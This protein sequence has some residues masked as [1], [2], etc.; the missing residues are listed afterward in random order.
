MKGSS[1]YNSLLFSVA[2]QIITGLVELSALFIPVPAPYVFLKQMMLLELSIQIIEGSFYAYW[3]YNFKT[4][5]NVTPT[6]YYDWG[7]TT[8]T[9]LI[10]LIMYLIFLKDKDKQLDFLQVFSEE[11]YTIFPVLML[12]W[13]MLLFGFLS[14]TFVIPT[15]TAVT[16]GFIPF[17]LYYY[18]IYEKYA[19]FTTEGLAI[20]NYFL[21]FWAIYGI[22]AYFP[23]NIKNTFYNILD[24]FSKNFFG[25]FLFYIIYTNKQ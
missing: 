12:N 25:I 15:M 8:P 10:N 22:A 24:L 18:I 6:R 2:I 11:I 9:M 21:F 13:L 7:I 23:Y 20:F 14:E 16:L 17:A 4:I 5:Q 3:L 19:K 1:I